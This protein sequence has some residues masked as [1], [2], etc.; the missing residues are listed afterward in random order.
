[1]QFT[2]KSAR[3][4]EIVIRT[5]VGINLNQ[6]R[7]KQP[8]TGIRMH[9]GLKE[10]TPKTTSIPFFNILTL[11]TVGVNIRGCV[12]FSP[13]SLLSCY[14]FISLRHPDPT[15][16]APQSSQYLRM[17]QRQCQLSS[18]LPLFFFFYSL[19]TPKNLLWLTP[20]ACPH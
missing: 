11:E 16:E 14:L 20:P 9:S 17:M 8:D 15:A 1:M 4:T 3:V 10:G 2:S 13:D 7:P 18:D 5:V 12:G 6:H 19:S